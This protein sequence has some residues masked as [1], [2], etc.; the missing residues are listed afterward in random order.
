MTGPTPPR[1]KLWVMQTVVCDDCVRGRG[2]MCNSPGCTFAGLDTPGFRPGDRSLMARVVEA[3]G[4]IVPA[5][6]A[7]P[8]PASRNET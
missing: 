3:G 2:L 4:S 8:P 1:P 7:G 6:T 5:D